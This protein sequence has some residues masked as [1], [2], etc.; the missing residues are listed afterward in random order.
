[1]TGDEEVSDGVEVSSGVEDS[2]CGRVS[3]DVEIS[4]GVGDSDVEVNGVAEVDR[5]ADREGDG[6]HGQFGPKSSR[7]GVGEEDADGSGD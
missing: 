1:M 5:D 4:G 6:G 2:E 3:D 7:D